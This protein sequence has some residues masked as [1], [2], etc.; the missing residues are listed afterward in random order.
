MHDWSREH[1][2]SYNLTEK[3]NS[4]GQHF[5]A[6]SKRLNSLSRINYG[7]QKIQI[8]SNFLFNNINYKSIIIVKVTF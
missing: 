4:W 8:D 5:F 2:T 7:D 6:G 3:N 1:I